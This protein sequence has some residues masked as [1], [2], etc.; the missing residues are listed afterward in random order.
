MVEVGDVLAPLE[1]RQGDVGEARELPE[2]GCITYARL[3]VVK[4][5]EY[6]TEPAPQLTDGS[7][8]HGERLPL[9][10]DTGNGGVAPQA[11]RVLEGG[12]DDN[13]ATFMRDFAPEAN[14]RAIAVG[15]PLVL[16]G[17]GR[18]DFLG[19]VALLVLDKDIAEAR[20][21]KG[22]LA[23]ILED[24]FMGDGVDLAMLE[25]ADTASIG[26][27]IGNVVIPPRPDLDLNL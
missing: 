3:I 24:D 11:D 6:L 22:E 27:P 8:A 18:V 20:S 2:L 21:C 23:A 15:N 12:A 10:V 25:E 9:Y 19:G 4:A 1:G 26:L 13:L 7:L 5:D 17:V 16:L 14:D